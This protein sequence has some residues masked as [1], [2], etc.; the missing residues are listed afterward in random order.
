MRTVLHHLPAHRFV[1]KTDVKGY[2]AS[3]D[4]HRLLDQLAAWITIG[5]C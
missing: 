5:A 2:Y 3:I 4:H 1:L